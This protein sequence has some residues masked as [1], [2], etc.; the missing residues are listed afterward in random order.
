MRYSREHKEQTAAKIRDA[1]RRGFR[2]E[3]YAG[4]SVDAIAEAAGVT[5]G[6]FYSH[7]RSKSD[8]FREI[9]QEGMANLGEAV[10]SARSKDPQNWV[11]QF[12]RWYLSFPHKRSEDELALPIQGACALPTLSP[13]V[14]R[15]DEDTREAYEKELTSLLDAVVE[16]LPGSKRD[17]RRT[18]WA[19]LALLTGSIV[20]A[21]AVPSERMAK[22]ITQSTLHAVLR[23]L[24]EAQAEAAEPNARSSGTK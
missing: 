14:A 23:L 9:V 24:A 13:E 3:G 16:G 20:L 15:C 5:S 19:Y 18:A 17:A 8:A 6:A 11:A 1:I 12:S 22:E 4:L 7:F 2:F 21:R 10:R